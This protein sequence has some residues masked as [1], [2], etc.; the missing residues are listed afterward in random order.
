MTFFHHLQK[1]ICL[2][3]NDDRLLLLQVVDPVR[4]VQQT[5]VG[6][7]S[8]SAQLRRRAFRLT[9]SA[10]LRRRAFRVFNT[11]GHAGK[12]QLEADNPELMS[13]STLSR[14]F[15]GT[16]D[17]PTAQLSNQL[18]KLPLTTWPSPLRL[19]LPLPLPFPSPSPSPLHY[20]CHYRYHYHYHYH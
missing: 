3:A 9:G 17:W 16:N 12:T 5:R 19:P 4:H 13:S 18:I 2:L 8:R 7:A 1:K 20:H 6:V 15:Y 14:S 10:R 11:G